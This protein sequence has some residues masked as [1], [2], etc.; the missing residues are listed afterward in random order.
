MSDLTLDTAWLMGVQRQLKLFHWQTQNYGHHMALG[1]AHDTLTTEIDEF[2]EC[3]AGQTRVP[4]TMAAQIKGQ[5]LTDFV[6]DKQVRSYVKQ[7]MTHAMDRGLDGISKILQ[8]LAYL[9]RMQ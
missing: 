7:C 8:K 5:P 1:Q 2:F 3:G 9:L 4:S 6:S